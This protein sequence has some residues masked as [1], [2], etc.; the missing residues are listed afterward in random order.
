[1][2]ILLKLLIFIFITALVVQIAGCCTWPKEVCQTLN[3]AGKNRSNLEKVLMHYQNTD[4]PLKY[5]AAVFLISNISDHGFADISFFNDEGNEVPFDST[6]YANFDEALKDFQELEKNHGELTHKKKEYIRDVDVITAD[7]LIENIELAFESWRQNPWSRKMSFEAFCHTILPYRISNEPLDRWRKPC[8]QRYADLPSQLQ[9]ISD[10]SDAARLIQADVDQWIR[11]ND[12]YYLHP[13]D[14]SYS[15]M[16]HSKQGRC[17]D[18]TNMTTFAMRA[19]AVATASDYTPAWAN[20]DNNHAWTAI[21]DRNGRGNAELFNI[22]AKVYRKTFAIQ[23]DSPI[24]QKKKNEQIP[25]WLAGR[26]YLDVT[27]Q[28]VKTTDVTIHCTLPAPKHSTFVYLCVFNGG[29]WAPIAA[30]QLDGSN[31]TFE[32]MGRDIVYLPAYYADDAIHPAAPALIIHPDGSLQ[33]LQADLTGNQTVTIS[34]TKPE[35]T[36]DDTRL[37]IA[38]RSVEPGNIYELFVWDDEWKSLGQQTGG[39]TPIQHQNLNRG[40]LYWLT[41]KDGRKLERVFTIENGQQIW[42]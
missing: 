26:H 32:R 27:E 6:D 4:D 21:L 35:I 36:D 20:R 8:M 37:R 15:Q 19:N 3:D 34:T 9:D 12:K 25:P 18:I 38:T 41:E 2:R 16:C 13:T 24:F 22:P 17:E 1:M 29:N 23:K 31:A 42:W 30:A 40:R 39:Q 33:H 28:Y 5:D 10:P 7:F 14:Q 11:F